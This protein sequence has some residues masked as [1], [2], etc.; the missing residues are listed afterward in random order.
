MTI[1]HL[2]LQMPL[3]CLIPVSHSPA[4]TA[5]ILVSTI[6]N[7]FHLP[8]NFKYTG[9][10]SMSGFLPVSPATFLPS[11]VACLCKEEKRVGVE[12]ILDSCLPFTMKKLCYP[13]QFSY[14]F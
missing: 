2:A 8:L 7:Q 9:Q 3:S 10:S 1:C 11:S 13:D 4:K 5:M 12:S 14:F 6:I